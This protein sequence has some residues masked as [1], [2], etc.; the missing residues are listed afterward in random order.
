[1]LLSSETC[2]MLCERDLDRGGNQVALWSVRVR[3]GAWVIQSPCHVRQ[4][5]S[6]EG[7]S[8][9]GSA[10]GDGESG[11][12]VSSLRK[13]SSGSLTATPTD[14]LPVLFRELSAA[15]SWEKGG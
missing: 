14:I 1:M 9:Y 8:L 3:E 15:T 10:E 12:A 6:S 5:P 7:R 4:A 13:H 11:G 2:T